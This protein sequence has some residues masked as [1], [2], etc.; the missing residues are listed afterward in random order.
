MKVR[1]LFEFASEPA[2]DQHTQQT[3]GYDQYK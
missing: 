1:V 3:D 2:L